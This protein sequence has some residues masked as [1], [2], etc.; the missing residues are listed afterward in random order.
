M[1]V[2]IP[3]QVDGTTLQSVG[4]I[5]GI[6]PS[7]V[8]TT[9]V[10]DL[11]V[12]A[13]KVGANVATQAELDAVSTALADHEDDEGLSNHIP[14]T[15]LTVAMMAAGARPF[16]MHG[17]GTVGGLCGSARVFNPNGMNTAGLSAA[18]SKFRITR[19]VTVKNF[20]VKY[21]GTVAVG[22]TCIISLLKNGVAFG[23]PISVTFQNSDGA[24]PEKT[25]SDTGTLVAG[26]DLSVDCAVTVTP[27]ANDVQWAFDLELA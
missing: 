15:G 21:T 14:A 7:G 11:A 1:Q 27:G 23:T 10:A 9:E 13:P 16:S 6:K 8:G 4:G 17:G 20:R 18:Q 22:S 5:I 25:D 26:D 3:S 2:S 12:T 19:A 24:N